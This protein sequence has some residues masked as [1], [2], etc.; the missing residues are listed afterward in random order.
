V[1]TQSPATTDEEV[2]L[3]IDQLTPAGATSDEHLLAEELV[4]ALKAAE[5]GFYSWDLETN[6][7][8][9]S[10]VARQLFDPENENG[11]DV[12]VLT[13]H[14][15]PEDLSAIVTAR[16][17]ALRTGFLPLSEYRISIGRMLWV[18]E[19]GRVQFGA[20]GRAT[21]LV[22]L[23]RS[24][25]QQ[26]RLESE[27]DDLQ[28]RLRAAEQAL[29]ESDARCLVATE[30]AGLGFW[31]W[32]LE[33]GT[34]F[35][36][37]EHYRI[38]GLD[39]RKKIESYAIFRTTVFPDDVEKIDSVFQSAIETGKPFSVDYRILRQRDGTLRWIVT[40]GQRIKVTGE[41]PRLVGIVRDVTDRK[42]FEK[43]LRQH[44]VDLQKALDLAEKAKARAEAAAAAKDKFL[45]MLSHELRTPLTPVL[46]TSSFLQER[47]DL[48]ADVQTALGMI[49]RN[50]DLEARLIDD[51]LDLTLITQNRIELR[52]EEVDVNEVLRR[53]LQICE[54]ERKA[55]K[56]HLYEELT[57]SRTTVRG[58]FARLQQ[59]L[60]NLLKNAIKF[61]PPEGWI[62]IRSRNVAGE[63]ELSI[64][65]SGVGISPEAIGRIFEPFE[66]PDSQITGKFGGMGLGLAISKASVLAHNGSLVAYSGGRDCGATFSVR[67]PVI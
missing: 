23:V 31:D 45:A 63:F 8:R 36:S 2:S 55:K 16:Q 26:K 39:S 14:V 59:V 33:S 13:R 67:L 7:V 54:S 1:R 21:R 5:T 64:S 35:W 53:A 38:F 18:A 40:N 44:E 51:L 28:A 42:E 61:T 12:S 25:E 19:R 32:N 22:A 9:L 56:L 11:T 27:S 10:A 20:S 47:S 17:S 48:P 30:A 57:A 66:Q 24:I 15:L 62:S 43:R 34:L 49:Q 29:D 6:Q 52:L 41:P 37:D 58:D 50:V 46:L 60:W 4:L 3:P 65:D